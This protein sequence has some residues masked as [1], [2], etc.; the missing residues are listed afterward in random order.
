LIDN[1]EKGVTK[2]EMEKAA[3]RSAN[4]HLYSLIKLKGLPI[5][6]FDGKYYYDPTGK[7]KKELAGKE[8][9]KK[10]APKAK[11]DKKLEEETKAKVPATKKPVPKGKK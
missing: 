4:S 10:P 7:K 3:G 9:D 8:V 11:E 5:F 6:K 2:E 1:Q